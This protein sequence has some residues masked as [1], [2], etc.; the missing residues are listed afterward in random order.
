MNHPLD[1]R[2]PPR[3]GRRLAAGAA[4]LAVAAALCWGLYRVPTPLGAWAAALPRRLESVLAAWLAPGFAAKLDALQTECFTLR[5]CAAE[6]DR[7]RVE[8]AALRALT[9]CD[10]QPEG[11]WQPVRV[12]ARSADG[13]FV[14]P[15]GTATAG[16]PV[17]DELGRLAGVVAEVQDG[18]ARVDPPGVGAGAVPVL[19]GSSAGVLQR[20]GGQLWATGLPRHCGL[21]AGATVTTVEGLWAG[22]LARAPKPDDTGLRESAPLA[23][24]ENGAG[25]V[26]FLPVQ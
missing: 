19:C 26:V 21:D 8:N 17:L 6:A 5:I 1:L 13:G 23:R 4:A 25:A 7:L 18:C 9:G 20:R 3:R 2:R 11:Q 12:T 14:L 10:A 22:T 24:H 16:Q 15:A